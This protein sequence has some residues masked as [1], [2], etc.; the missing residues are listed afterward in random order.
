M[1]NDTEQARLTLL[2][3]AIVE[4][5]DYVDLEEDIAGGIPR[6]GKTKRIVSYHNF[7]ETPADLDEIHRRL[8][9]KD[10][11]IVKRVLRLFDAL[12]VADTDGLLVEVRKAAAGE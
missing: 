1:W 3:T 4:G 5:A 8:A 10:A 6:Y 2:R 11:D 9:S 7:R 12:A